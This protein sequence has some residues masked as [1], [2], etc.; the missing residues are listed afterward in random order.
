MS[1]I[2]YHTWRCKLAEKLYFI[3]GVRVTAIKQN[4]LFCSYCI[5]LFYFISVYG[6]CASGPYSTTSICCERVYNKSYKLFN[7]L[8]C[9][10]VVDLLH[11]LL[12]MVFYNKC[13]INRRE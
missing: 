7:I 11:N 2:V 8:T 5:R 1:F 9:R 10:F 12:Y 6:T 4:K 13:A 3:A